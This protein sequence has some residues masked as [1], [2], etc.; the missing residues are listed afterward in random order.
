MA[1]GT[2]NRSGMGIARGSS[3]KATG[4]GTALSVTLGF[5]P[6]H[7][8]IYN[9]TDVTRWEK[10]DGMA[11]ANSLKTVAAGTCTDDNTSAI[12]FA[13]KGFVTSAALNAAG[14]DLYWFAE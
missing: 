7:V 1:T 2:V 3:G 5:K 13:E 11:D 10:F 14:K 6:K 8:I 12:V 4:D 9:R